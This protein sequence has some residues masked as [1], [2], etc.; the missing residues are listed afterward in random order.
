GPVF[1][2]EPPVRS[3]TRQAG[4][5]FGQLAGCQ[6]VGEQ[7]GAGPV[8]VDEI[9]VRRRDPFAHERNT[10]MAR[11]QRTVLCLQVPARTPEWR[12]SWR[13]IDLRGHGRRLWSLSGRALWRLLPGGILHH[14]TGRRRSRPWTG[15]YRRGDACS[16]AEPGDRGNTAAG[17]RLSR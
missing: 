13:G 2:R 12:R 3:G 1:F 8:E 10:V 15:R 6:T 5:E 16:R 11:N 7:A 4:I 9:A 14:S 17:R